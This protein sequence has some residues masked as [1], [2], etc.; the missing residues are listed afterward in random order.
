[1]IREPKTGDRFWVQEHGEFFECTL[2]E[3]S[4]K[5][6]CPIYNGTDSNGTEH[7][8]YF[9]PLSETKEEYEKMWNNPQNN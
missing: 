1:M 4:R 8:W 7:G 3:T 9:G 5:F 2:T 6:G